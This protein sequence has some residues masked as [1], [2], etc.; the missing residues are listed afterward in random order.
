MNEEH[1][2]MGFDSG[3]VDMRS[4]LRNSYYKMLSS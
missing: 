4:S 2:G 1:A 3:S